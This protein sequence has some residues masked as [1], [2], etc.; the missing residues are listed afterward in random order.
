[1]RNLAHNIDAR[2]SQQASWL[3]LD[4]R[5]LPSKNPT[6]Q[7]QHSRMRRLRRET[8]R[9]QGMRKG[10]V[11]ENGADDGFGDLPAAFL[12][13]VV[14]VFVLGGFELVDEEREFGE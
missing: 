11:A 6:V 9:V 8:V 3:H 4:P 1:M 2:R 12:L 10:V 5:R 7:V 13:L 14:V